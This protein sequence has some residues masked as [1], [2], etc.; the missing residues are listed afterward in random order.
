MHLSTGSKHEPR[1]ATGA[2]ASRAR[3]KPRL[4]SATR[5]HALGGLSAGSLRSLV[6]PAPPMGAWIVEYSV[7]EIGVRVCLDPETAERG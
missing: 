5:A 1:P 4:G 3:C 2:L 6:R 7:L